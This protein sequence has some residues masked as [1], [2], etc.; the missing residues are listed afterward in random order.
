MNRSA[1]ALM[2]ATCLALAACGGGGGDSSPGAGPA[3]TPAPTPSARTADVNNISITESQSA[4]ASAVTTVNAAV[5]DI[6]AASDAPSSPLG[7]ITLPAG[8]VTSGTFPCDSGNVAYQLEYDAGTNRPISYAFTYNNCRYSTGGG[9]AQYN[10]TVSLA[11][12]QYTNSTN[13]TL[14]QNYNLNYQVVSSSYN[15]SGTLSGSTTCTATNGALSCSYNVGANGVSNATVSRSGTVTTVTRATVSSGTITVS[16][17]NWVYDASTGRATSG[18]VTVS[19]GRGNSVTIEVVSG[20]YR[21][22]VV[23]DGRTT[24]YTVSYAA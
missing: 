7:A 5:A 9:Y 21:V 11:Y 14:T 15:S 23:K 16:Y 18:T 3:P 2:L 22:T 6:V 17:S 8:A 4:A 12:T 20:G 1:H 13:Y 10:G 19:D 24:V